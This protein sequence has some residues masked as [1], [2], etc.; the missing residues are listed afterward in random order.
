MHVNGFDQQTLFTKMD[1]SKE[2]LQNIISC[3]TH[4]CVFLYTEMHVTGFSIFVN[5]FYL[6]SEW[7]KY[8]I[9]MKLSITH[10]AGV[11]LSGKDSKEMVVKWVRETRPIFFLLSKA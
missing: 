9:R 8:E 1:K 2:K 11:D 7:S 10:K 5:D 4:V 6:V 3:A